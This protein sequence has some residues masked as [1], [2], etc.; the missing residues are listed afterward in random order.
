ML[1]KQIPFSQF[2]DIIKRLE[3]EADIETG[4]LGW[5]STHPPADERM[6]AFR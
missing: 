3:K 1:A 2:T 4:T 6:Q 5:M